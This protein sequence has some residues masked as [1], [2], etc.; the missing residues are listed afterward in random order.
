MA[1]L[2]I[3]S[4]HIIFVVSWFAGLFYIVRLFIYHTEAEDRPEAERR[5][6]QMQFVL[7]EK[8]L[9]NIITTPAMILTVLSGLTMLWVQ[10][11]YL[12]QTWMWVKISMVAGL[13][14]YHFYCQKIVLELRQSH[15][16]FN[17]FQLRIWNEVAT[18]FLVAIVFIVELQNALNWI[19][20]VL[21]LFVFAMVL[22]VAIRLYR[23]AREKKPA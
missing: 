4:V 10:P 3:K 8:K 19:W 9:W 6:L 1:L 20:G 17:S 21:G 13:L 5:I 16:R 18:L 2:Y 12:S 15:F 11:A 22:M 23:K 14:L 7:M